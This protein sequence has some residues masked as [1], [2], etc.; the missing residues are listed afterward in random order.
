VSVKHIDLGL[1][2][3]PHLGPRYI[4]LGPHSGELFRDKWLEPAFLANDQ[5]VIN[6]D[7]IEG[8]SSSFFEEAFG[9]LVRKHGLA[10]VKAKV[11]F[12]TVTR[13]YLVPMIEAWMAEAEDDREGEGR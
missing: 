12:D 4:K 7:S 1:E 5:V 13:Q 10:A 2:F 11:R 3:S 8:Y 9:G 6:L